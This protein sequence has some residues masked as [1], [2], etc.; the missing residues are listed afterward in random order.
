MKKRKFKDLNIRYY[1]LGAIFLAFCAVFCGRLVYYQIINRDDYA[2]AVVGKNTRREVAPASRGNI[3]DRNGKVLVT[4]KYYRSAVI[5]YDALPDTRSGVHA[6]FL[7][8]LDAVEATNSTND[9]EKSYFPFEGT[10]PNYTYSE[11]A[12]KSGVARI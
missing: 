1:A 6:V 5:D 3:C 9:M 8:L 12:R 2:T 11:A 7:S 10:F 4:S